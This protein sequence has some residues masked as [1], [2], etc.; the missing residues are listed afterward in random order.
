MTDYLKLPHRYN[1]VYFFSLFS[2][3]FCQFFSALFLSKFFIENTFFRLRTS[4]RF[5][6][7]SSHFTSAISQLF[8]HYVH[9]F[10]YNSKHFVRATNSVVSVVSESVSIGFWLWDTFSCFHICY[11]FCCMLE[12][13]YQTFVIFL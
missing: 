9:Y 2:L 3:R 7:Y 8:T 11:M 4:I 1:S 10:L 12:N 5:S 6:V 13:I